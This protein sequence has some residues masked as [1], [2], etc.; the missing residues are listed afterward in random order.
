MNQSSHC[1]F[2]NNKLKAIRSCSSFRLPLML[3]SSFAP[4]FST[5][6]RQTP[7]AAEATARHY[8]HLLRTHRAKCSK[9]CPQ[10]K[11]PPLFSRLPLPPTSTSLSAGNAVTNATSQSSPSALLPPKPKTT[12]E[13]QTT[14]S[15]SAGKSTPRKPKTRPTLLWRRCFLAAARHLLCRQSS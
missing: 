9:K 2:R 4:I 13:C 5:F 7:I 11:P 14:S 10:P 3:K 1:Q 15:Y 8:L 6:P 12:R